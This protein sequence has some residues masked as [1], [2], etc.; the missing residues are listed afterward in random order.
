MTKTLIDVDD[1][2]L[3]RA[4]ELTGAA[5]KKAAVNEAL[6]QV[7][8]RGEALGYIDLLSTGIVVELDD[9]DVIDGAQR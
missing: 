2:L 6:A 7:V 1:A 4:M 3:E 9:P 8:R 5:T